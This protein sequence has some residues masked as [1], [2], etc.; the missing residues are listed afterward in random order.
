MNRNPIL[1][2]LNGTKPGQISW[3]REFVGRILVYG[4]VPILALLGAQFPD[5][6]GQIV[7]HIIPNEAMHQQEACSPRANSRASVDALQ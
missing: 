2:Y 4:L 7:S 5:S 6:A 3:D 1:S